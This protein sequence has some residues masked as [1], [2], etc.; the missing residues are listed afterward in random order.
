L[1]YNFAF[2]E[3][4]DDVIYAAQ[5]N[6][7]VNGHEGL[8]GSN[9]DCSL[10]DI[11]NPDDAFPFLFDAPAGLLASYST[12]CDQYV[13]IDSLIDM[14]GI[15]GMFP[16]NESTVE[17]SICNEPCSSPGEMCFSNT[18]GECFSNSEVLEWLN[19]YVDEENMP[20]LIDYAE[21]GSDA[22]YVPKEQATRKVTLVLDLD[23]MLLA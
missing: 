16:L 5:D 15:C 20:N 2:A 14:S 1:I 11:Y 19:P 13:S 18:G 23:G 21:L 4:A 8:L 12:L 6:C 7:A 3:A 9:Q 17:T 10:L 22:A